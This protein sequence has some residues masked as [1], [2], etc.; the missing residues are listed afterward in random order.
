MVGLKLQAIKEKQMAKDIDDADN[1]ALSIE[2][3]ISSHNIA[4]LLDEEDQAEIAAKVAHGYTIDKESRAEWEVRNATALELALQIA[5]DKTTPWVGAANVK[6]PMVTIAALQCHAREYP[7]L[8]SGTDIVRCRVI[9]ND[10]DGQLTA[11]A[12]RISAHMSYQVMEEDS[13]WEDQMDRVM[14]TKPIIGTAFKKVYFDATLGHNVSEMILAQ[15]LV[16]PYYAKS[17]EKAARITHVMQLSNN[18]IHERVLRGVFLDHV[19]TNTPGQAAA[20]T[21]LTQVY[22]KLHGVRPAAGDPD[23]PHTV[24]EQHCYLDLDED[25]YAEPYI[26]TVS[27]E[28]KKLLRIVARYFSEDITYLDGK[29]AYINPQQFFVKYGMIPSPDGGIYDLGFGTLL[30]PLNETVNTLINQLLDAGTLSN[31]GGGFVGRGAK[32]PKGRQEMSMGQYIQVDCPGNNLR[33]NIVPR[34]TQ[35]P[36]Q[37]LFSLLGMLITYGER[38]AGAT[39]IMTG[40][41]IGQNTPAGT[42]QEMVTQGSMVF[43]AIFKRTYRSLKDEFRLLYRLNQLYVDKNTSFEELSTGNSAVILAEDYMGS[44]TQIRPAADPNVTSADKRMKQ[45]MLLKQ[46]AASGPGYNAIAVE[47]R[48]LEAAQI[49]FIQEIWTGQA[50]EPQPDVKLQIAQMQLQF[51]QMELQI[52]TQLK[53]VELL[54]EAD[55]VAAD[56]K[57]MEAKAENEIAKAQG[58]GAYQVIALLNTEI[59]A[60][61]HHQDSIMHSVQI[62]RDIIGVHKDIAGGAN[63][64]TVGGGS[65]AMATPPSNTEQTAAVTSGAPTGDAGMA[66]SGV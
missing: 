26:V 15:D 35:D 34:P 33:E 30:G 11:R 31:M 6:F 50:A 25:G 54:Q 17:L 56:I 41:N 3:L 61:K 57:L 49:P 52:T 18:E 10:P 40:E 45:A 19:A 22:D 13:N 37:V 27:L 48:V 4:E 44:A 64:G 43:N 5:R 63:E 24:I 46:L 58:E 9:G 7:A 29:V 55:K 38:I 32:I 47:K 51:K 66:S 2:K 16:L 1:D 36:S 21:A 42:A 59:A 28:D 39:E 60:K 65:Q 12:N 23:T 20:S 14:V 8:I 62:L 53:T